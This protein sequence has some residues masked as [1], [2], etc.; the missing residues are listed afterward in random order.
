MKWYLED[1]QVE[2]IVDLK[3]NSGLHETHE[4][5]EKIKETIRLVHFLFV[6]WIKVMLRVAR[7][8]LGVIWVW[9]LGPGLER[10]ERLR[11]DL[12]WAL[13]QDG[14]ITCNRKD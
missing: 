7:W 6:V 8:L 1:K 4:N 3:L 10:S 11:T 12:S 5:D 14:G 9:V 13:G 2:Q